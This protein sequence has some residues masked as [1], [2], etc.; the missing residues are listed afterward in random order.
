MQD[1]LFKTKGPLDP[2]RDKAILIERRELNTIV[3]SA[4]QASVPSYLALLSPR[5][6]GKTTLL[7]HARAVLQQRG[8][9]I[10]FVDL[11][12]LEAQDE[13]SC[14]QFVATQI[15]ADLGGQLRLPRA[16][17]AQLEE[18][19][20]PIA[21]RSFLWEIAHRARPARLVILLDEVKAIPSQVSGG[22][23]GTIRS[24]FTSRQKE[25]DEV[26]A[27]YLFVFSGAA[28]L[29]DLT[30]GENSP[31]NICDTIYL[32]DLN[33]EETWRL[34][35]NL[36]RLGVQVSRPESDY[37][38]HQ[39]GGH[40]YLTQRICSILEIHS[41]PALNAPVVDEAI[42]EMMQGD[43]NLEHITRQLDRE[44]KARALLRRIM[45]DGRRVRFSPVDPAISRLRM[46]GV[47][48][49]Q[50]PCAVRNPI[51]EQALQRYFDLR[52]KA[53]LPFVTVWLALLRLFRRLRS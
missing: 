51:Y 27:K 5:Q 50:D 13:E 48:S 6:T 1:R 29:Y 41:V 2:I 31:L 30:T 49:D 16:A 17:R 28:E 42:A 15:L 24:V 26:F 34:V 44:P 36:A 32:S 25:N 33:A 20:G 14:Y 52:P 46:I 19:K 11:S 7:Y 8:C 35:S 37:L 10:A 9:A 40:P 43:D 4:T 23:F 53:K 21:F 22:F 18:V 47:I 45:A 39:T 38:Y 12:P 3:R